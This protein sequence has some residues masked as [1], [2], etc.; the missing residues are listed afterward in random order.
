MILTIEMSE[1]KTQIEQIAHQLNV[2][3]KEGCAIL[4]EEYGRGMV[5]W[6]P[7]VE[8]LDV[9]YY[10]FC[11]S[12]EL[13]VKSNTPTEGGKF[14][15]QISLSS[16]VLEKEIAGQSI[17]LSRSLPAGILFYS[18]GNSSIGGSPLNVE[19]EIAFISFSKKF[20]SH[21]PIKNSEPLDVDKGF[22]LYEDLSP[23]LEQHLRHILDLDTQRTSHAFTFYTGILHVIGQ[24]L[25][26]LELRKASSQATFSPIEVE[27]LFKVR[28][29]LRAHIFDQAPK[30]D[31]LSQS[32]GV[33]STNLK[34]QFKAFFGKPVYQYYLEL[35][36]EAAKG[37][38]Q[39]GQPLPT[40]S[41]VGYQLGYSNI[42]QFI[43]AFKKYQGQTPKA[44]QSFI[45]H[46]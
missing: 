16:Q 30:L 25:S 8:G 29:S 24:I 22:C 7:V 3:I 28:E 12:K 32:I 39:S 14:V 1:G 17:K 42:S 15:M 31:E 46:S 37:L 18:P 41:E 13:I 4:P 23:P 40:I 20:L 11:L 19:V 45:T 27:R 9:H 36:M 26:Q 34:Y 38:L 21:L 5:Q 35:K 44:Y 6:I 10:Q 33:S 43:K 2:P